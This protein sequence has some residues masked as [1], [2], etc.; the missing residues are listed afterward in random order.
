M[1]KHPWKCAAFP[2]FAILALTAGGCIN[3]VSWLPDSSG[4]VFTTD[5]EPG[6]MSFIRSMCLMNFGLRATNDSVCHD[7]EPGHSCSAASDSRGA[8]SY[9]SASISF[10]SGRP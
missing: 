1:F 6:G 2:L 9:L 5:S 8:G 10:Q 7:E 4:F 3:G